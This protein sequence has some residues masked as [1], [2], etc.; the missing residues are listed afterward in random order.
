[1]QGDR[2][3][4]HFRWF[5]DVRSTIV[6]DEG[7]ECKMWKERE[8]ARVDIASMAKVEIHDGENKYKLCKAQEVARVGIAPAKCEIHDEGNECK[9]CKAQEAEIIFLQCLLYVI[10]GLLF[11]LVY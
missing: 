8:V 2:G 11:G 10:I 4:G 6:H 3:C 9:M 1:M 7:N 5:D